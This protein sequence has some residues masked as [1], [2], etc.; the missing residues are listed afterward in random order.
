MR[1]DNFIPDST[2]HMTSRGRLPHWYRDEATYSITFRLN[3]SLPRDVAVN[4]IRRRAHLLATAETAAERVRIDA[5]FGSQFDAALDAGAGSCLFHDAGRAEIV[6]NALRHHDRT[7]YELHA[8][9]VMPNH[10]HALV[11]V[12]RGAE[13]RRIVQAWKSYTA[14]AIGRGSI[15]QREYF[16][17]IIRDAEDFHHVAKYIRA[18]PAKAGLLDSP[19]VG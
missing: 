10:V 16:D 4:L 2:L 19:W 6:A 7:R 9:C 8:W 1:Y 5:M 3:D 12:S 14:H 18:N 15:W 13:L 11:Y 17:R